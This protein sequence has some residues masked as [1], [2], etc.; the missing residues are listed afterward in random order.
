MVK[1]LLDKQV[2]YKEDYT[3]DNDDKG[4]EMSSYYHDINGKE[5]EIVLGNKRTQYSDSKNIIFMHIYQFVNDKVS[6]KIGIFEI[7]AS[8]F[9]HSLDDD[10]DIILDN[11]NIIFFPKSLQEII[12]E[13]PTPEGIPEP[14]QEPTIEIIPEPI[15]ESKTQ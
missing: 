13:P 9:I 2:E 11:G 10:G 8:E 4:T 14:T 1:S 7:K 3:I 12:Q 5:I 15:K 6:K